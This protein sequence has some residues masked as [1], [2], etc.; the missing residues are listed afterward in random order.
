MGHR[1]RQPKMRAWPCGVAS[2]VAIVL[3][4]TV[5][6]SV[7]QITGVSHSVHEYDEDLQ[8][9]RLVTTQKLKKGCSHLV[10]EFEKIAEK[11]NIPWCPWNPAGDEK[12]DTTI[13]WCPW[14]PAGDEK[15]DTTRNQRTRKS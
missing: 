14:N 4:T 5:T 11:N 12:A 2:V 15:A 1:T 6:I 3:S 13:P 8:T 9:Q 7:A 10:D